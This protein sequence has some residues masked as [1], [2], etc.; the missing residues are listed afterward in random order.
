MAKK[1]VI[2]LIVVA[3][4]VF[5]LVYPQ[6]YVIRGSGGGA[7]YWNATE[8]LL[9]MAGGRSGAHMSYLRYAME[10]FLLSMGD[11]RSPDDGRCSHILVIRVTGKDV[12]YYDTGLYREAEQPECVSHYYLIA[13]QIYEGSLAK[14]WKWAGTH[15][16]PTTPEETSG[17]DFGKYAESLNPHP[18][19][20]DDRDDWS[21]RQLGAVGPKYQFKGRP[22]TLTQVTLG[23]Q[24]LSFIFS[25][26]TFPQMP[27]SVDL[28]RSGQSPQTIWN[29]DGRPHRVSKTEYRKIFGNH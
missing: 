23:G 9:F 20:F 16:E 29:F 5:L 11:V 2:V 28:V 21:M 13:G 1:Y 27:I 18:W 19:Y 22:V 7:L 6:V 15:F 8:A 17:F 25:G 4:I 10:P 24:P 3:G 14:L 12:Q 26:E